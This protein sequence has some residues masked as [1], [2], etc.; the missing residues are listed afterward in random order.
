MISL[1]REGSVQV[2]HF[3]VNIKA[4]VVAEDSVKNSRK[5]YSNHGQQDEK[6]NPSW[7]SNHI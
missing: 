2:L 6:Q 5:M 7:K 3:T 1:K 4:S